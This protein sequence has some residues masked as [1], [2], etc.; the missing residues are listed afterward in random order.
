MDEERISAKMIAPPP[1]PAR[2]I[3]NGCNRDRFRVSGVSLTATGISSSSDSDRFTG[4]PGK[5]GVFKIPLLK[6]LILERGKGNL[7]QLEEGSSELYSIS[8]SVL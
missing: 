4:S 2:I 5:S 8:F 6:V 1:N 3:R 7:F